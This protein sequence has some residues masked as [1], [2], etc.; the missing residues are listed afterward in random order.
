ML[1][2]EKDKDEIVEIV[3]SENSSS[4]AV[5]KHTKKLCGC[6]DIDCSD[7]LFCGC[8]NCSIK[9]N[10]WSNSEA[11]EQ[12][13]LTKAEKTILENVDKQYKWIARD[14][15]DVLWVYSN[16]PNKNTDHWNCYASSNNTIT[17]INA[18]NHLFQFIKWEDY[19]PYNIGYIL[20][21]CIIKED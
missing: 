13:I 3:T 7:C 8:D 19:E 2:K 15:N 11:I 12:I 18:F 5:N 9:R 20:A 17:R 6:G 16:K 21:N 10:E 14:E 1:N 4:F